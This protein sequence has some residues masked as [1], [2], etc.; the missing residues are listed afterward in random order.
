M[1]T[2]ET[3]MRRV[4]CSIGFYASVVSLN[5]RCDSKVK[6]GSYK[7][8]LGSRFRGSVANICMQ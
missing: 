4:L 5:R 2:F 3:D 8:L 6:K 1:N 7:K